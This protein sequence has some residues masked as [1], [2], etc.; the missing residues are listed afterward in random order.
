MQQCLSAKDEQ[1]KQLLTS[2]VREIGALSKR[3]YQTLVIT[4]L[5]QEKRGPAVEEYMQLNNH[6]VKYLMDFVLRQ[7]PE[8]VGSAIELLL[9]MADA[10]IVAEGETSY[11]DLNS[12]FALSACLDAPE[13]SRLRPYT[14]Q[15][16]SHQKSLLSE[17][18][19][20][21]SPLQNFGGVR[22]IA[23]EI[24]HHL[25][26]MAS[27]SRDITFSK[28]G[29]RGIKRYETYGISLEYTMRANMAMAFEP[30]ISQTNL[31]E[32]LKTWQPRSEEEISIDSYRLHPHKKCKVTL[33]KHY[34]NLKEVLDGIEHA[35]AQQRI[36]FFKVGR[37]TYHPADKGIEK[38][39]AWIH[40]ALKKTGKGNIV[41]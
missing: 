11:A 33:S 19:R 10:F 17:L 23:R 24:P 28:D 39:F 22:T 34:D 6:L 16:S 31:P 37:K 1:R 18:G 15:L 20:L 35:I 25:P 30:C 21:C 14:Q 40:K 12:L 2:V 9:D 38:C 3:L 32:M 26:F 13:I 5:V 29:N 8:Q 7:S 27:V 36:P 41:Y 4:D